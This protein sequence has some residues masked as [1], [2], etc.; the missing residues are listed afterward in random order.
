MLYEVIT[1]QAVPALAA[2]LSTPDPTLRAKAA[3]LLGRLGPLALPAAPALVRAL[4]CPDIRAMHV[5]AE[6]IDLV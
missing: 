1:E 4:D 6:A 5:I 3:W 2:L